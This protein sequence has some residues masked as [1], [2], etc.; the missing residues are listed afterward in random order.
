MIRRRMLFQWL[1][2]IEQAFGIPEG[3]LVHLPREERGEKT[4]RFHW[5]V[6]VGGLYYVAGRGVVPS[7]NVRSDIHILEALWKQ[8]GRN[9][10]FPDVREFDA[11]LSGVSY[12][13]KGLEELEW[14]YAGANAYELAK[15]AEDQ[16]G[17]ELI[18]APAFLTAVDR[19]LSRNRRHRKARDVKRR[20][21]DRSARGESSSGFVGPDRQA[22]PYDDVTTRLY[23]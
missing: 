6:L 15:F 1:R 7:P 14:S 11:Q 20:S 18:L 16:E 17:R 9:A 23:C 19:K 22:H 10:G 3:L 5:H 12:V 4:G 8:C 13:L 21:R 2:K